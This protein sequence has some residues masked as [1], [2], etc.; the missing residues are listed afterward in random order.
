MKET[1]AIKSKDTYTETG[2]MDLS[3]HYSFYAVCSN[4]SLH[5]ELLFVRKGVL[6]D[7]AKCPDCGCNTLTR[8]G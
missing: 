2:G 7:E 4:C 1:T 5:S 8:K 3:D 6:I